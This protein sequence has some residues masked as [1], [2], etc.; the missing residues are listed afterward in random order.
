MPRWWNRIALGACVM[1]VLG[2]GGMDARAADQEE[3]RK[4]RMGFTGFVYDFTPAAI[5]ESRR[6]VRENGDLIAHHIEGVPWAEALSGEPFSKAF[7]DEW[8]GK[9]AG[10][11]KGGKVYLA[12]SPGRGDL[13]PA[14]KAKPL[15]KELAGKNY[16]D[17]AVMKAYLNYCRRAI[18]FFHPDYLAIGIEVNEIHDAGAKKWNSY[19]AL[20]RYIYGEL[21][22]ENKTLPIFASWTLHNMFKKRGAMLAEFKKLMPY[23]DLVAV[24]YYPFFMKDQERLAALDWMMVEFSSFKKPFAMVETNDAAERLEF[25]T[26]KMV[27]NGT[28][29]KQADYY[30]RL[31]ALAQEKDFAFVVSFVHRDYDALWEKIK[32]FSPELFIAWKDCGLVDETGREREALGVWKKYLAMR[33]EGE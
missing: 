28:E 3:T 8:E 2:I 31:L 20:H 10:T 29:Q 12:I 13:K 27:I 30:A 18:E 14:E 11:P 1:M 7:L 19:A 22:K 32:A 4:F 15:P 21:R 25:P 23:N 16:D 5:E 9:K 17:P 24:S 6:F 33:L 26:S